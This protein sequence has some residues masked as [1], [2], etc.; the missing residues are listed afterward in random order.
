[1]TEEFITYRKFTDAESAEEVC[2]Q[3]REHSIEYKL[4]DSS[5]SYLK[6]IGYSQ[7]DPGVIVNI[8]PRDFK[9]ADRILDQYY[10]NLV[11]NVDKS[12]YIFEFSDDEL[13]DIVKNPYDWG[14][15]DLHL[16]KKL[17]KDKG[18]ELSETYVEE[19]KSEKLKELSKSKE[20][21]F[22]KI[23][24][25]YIFSF[26]LPAV[27]LIIGLL[28]VNTKNVL[29]NGHRLPAYSNSS[30]THGQVMIVISVIWATVVIFGMLI[31]NQ[32]AY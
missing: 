2:E 32:S 21:S 9:K 13:K 18:I 17:L 3:L 12:H 29:P 16:A 20:A 25:G 4:L 30:R 10:M 19:R 23:I 14:S 26:I 28:I 24:L 31:K 27:G 5:H 22:Y 6:V 1:M 15:L 11:E 8:K 7:I